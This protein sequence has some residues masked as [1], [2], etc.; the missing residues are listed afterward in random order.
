MNK[1]SAAGIH[2]RVMGK[3]ARYGYFQVFGWDI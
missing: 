2:E 3:M 1:L